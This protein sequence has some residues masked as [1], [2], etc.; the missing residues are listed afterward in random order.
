MV[1]ALS[2]DKSETQLNLASQEWWTGRLLLV[3]LS[4]GMQKIPVAV[5]QASFRIEQEARRAY[6]IYGQ[7]TLCKRKCPLSRWYV[8]VPWFMWSACVFGSFAVTV[9]LT[10]KGLFGTKEFD[11]TG[12][13]CKCRG[14]AAGENVEADWLMLVCMTLV[15]KY[16]M[17]QPVVLFLATCLHLCAASKLAARMKKNGDD[18]S[19]EKR[20]GS[21][22]NIFQ[23]SDGMGGMKA[24]GDGFHV[25]NPMRSST[26]FS[27]ASSEQSQQTEQQQQQQQQENGLEMTSPEGNCASWGSPVHAREESGGEEKGGEPPASVPTGTRGKTRYGTRGGTRGGAGGKMVLHASSRII[28][29]EINLDV[30]DGDGADG[31]DGGDGG[32]GGDGGGTSG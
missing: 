19:R 18:G 32:E 2:N 11:E 25:D 29:R 3:A 24:D 22:A 14:I 23:S 17:Y 9:L 20:G 10:S 12:V 8:L 28:R 26:T 30:A 31:S 15:F 7:R 21:A 13:P 6:A 1:A 4:L 16:V 27:G 5:V